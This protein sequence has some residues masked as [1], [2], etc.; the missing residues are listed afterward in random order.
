MDVTTPVT[1]SAPASGQPSP[2]L[3]SLRPN[4]SAEAKTARRVRGGR[5]RT[6]T[7]SGMLISAATSIAL[8]PSLR[9][10]HM[11]VYAESSAQVQRSRQQ[12]TRLS[13]DG[14]QTRR[15][16]EI[17]MLP[18]KLEPEEADRVADEMHV[19]SV[20]RR[21]PGEPTDEEALSEATRLFPYAMIPKRH[22]KVVHLIRHGEGV[23]NQ[24]VEQAGGRDVP[25][26][27]ALYKSPAYEDAQ[28]TKMGWQQVR[29]E[30]TPRCHV[31]T[32]A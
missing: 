19:T 30:S 4:P 22:T 3:P 28:L 12:G 20:S 29:A 32:Q 26:A 7:A 25:S 21:L 9:K 24:A 17:P 13:R 18:P 1:H 2:S 16:E 6:S 23:H 15:S 5:G 11:L 27:H 10:H 14:Q 8:A 31:P